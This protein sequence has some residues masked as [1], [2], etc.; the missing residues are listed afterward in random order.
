[1]S[2]YELLVVKGP[3]KGQVYPLKSDEVVIGR[4]TSCELSF[5]DKTLSRQHVRIVRNGDSLSIEDLDSANGVL[6]NGIRVSSAELKVDDR[7]TLGQIELLLRPVGETASP[8]EKLSPRVPPANE[9]TLPAQPPG[10][11]IMASEEADSGSIMSITQ[12][13]S[14]SMLMDLLGRSHQSLGAMYRVTRIASSIFNLDVLLNKVLDETFASIRAERGFVLLIDPNSDQL[15]LK[16]SRWQNKDGLDHNASISQNIIAHVL[17]KKE[18]VLI[19]DA[20]GDAKFSMADSVV[21]HN[22]R[23]AMCS[24][25]RGRTRIVGIIHADTTGVGEFTRRT[26]C[27][28]MPSAML[29]GSQWKTLSFTVKRFKM[30]D[31]LPWVKPFQGYLI[32]SRISLLLWTPLTPWWR[33]HW[34]LRT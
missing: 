25:L 18:S 8:L 29:L 7:I 15:E 5:D 26:L 13:L 2:I 23:S 12:S 4:D 24:P 28:W 20:M 3:E 10:Q 32:T 9:P 16:A 34:L 19:A 21:L 6:V 14:S 1:M 27:S 11:R 17:E 33:R 30:K 22:I 31:L